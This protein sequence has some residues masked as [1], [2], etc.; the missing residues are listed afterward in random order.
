M[1]EHPF[2][3][4]NSENTIR[5]IT[6]LTGSFLFFPREHV[7]CCSKAAQNNSNLWT[8]VSLK[9]LLFLPCYLLFMYPPS[10]QFRS[11]EGLHSLMWTILLSPRHRNLIA[12]MS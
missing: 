8:L 4:H 12:Q 3:Q 6:S 1:S 5:P 11:L 9:V 10:I 2:L 7:A